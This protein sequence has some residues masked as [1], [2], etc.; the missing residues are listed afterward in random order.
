MKR[1]HGLIARP[2][3]STAGGVV[4]FGET[5]ESVEAC[6]GADATDYI[7]PGFIDLQV[8]GRSTADVMNAS[9]GALCELSAQLAREGTTAWLATAITSPL[10]RLESVAAIIA[11]A[12]AE[13][14]SPSVDVGSAILGMHL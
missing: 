5:I 6:S 8:N 7:V 14:T 2:D 1:L 12:A 3:G 11:K 13:T 9:V 4:R 10:A